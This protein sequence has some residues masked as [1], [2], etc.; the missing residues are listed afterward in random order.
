MGLSCV[1]HVSHGDDFIRL[2]A[3]IHALAAIAIDPDFRPF[4]VSL[5]AGLCCC[6]MQQGRI[7]SE[8]KCIL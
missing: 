3:M 1:L 5:R 7:V 2:M 8:W 4:S 6:C